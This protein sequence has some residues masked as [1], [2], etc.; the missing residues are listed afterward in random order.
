MRTD[1]TFVLNQCSNVGVS[2]KF[3]IFPRVFFLN[4]EFNDFNKSSSHVWLRLS[5]YV[6]DDTC[7]LSIAELTRKFWYTYRKNYNSRQRRIQHRRAGRASPVWIFLGG[8]GV[9]VKIDCITRIYLIVVILQ[10]LQYVLCSLLSLQNIGYVWINGHQ[11]KPQTPRILPRRKIFFY[12]IILLFRLKFWEK[13]HMCIILH[14]VYPITKG[15]KYCGK[16]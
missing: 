12:F 16:G 13:R 7:N 5:R 10:C 9:F 11:N 14:V 15:H 2:L 1:F 8:G 6:Y 4:S 3:F